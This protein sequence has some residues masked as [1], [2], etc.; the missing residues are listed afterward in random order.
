MPDASRWSLVSDDLQFPESPV[1]SQRDGCLYLVEW[2]GDRVL[3]ICS[4]QQDT[5]FRLSDGSG[6]SGLCQA[7]DGSFWVC[8]FSGRELVHYN[9]KGEPIQILSNYHGAPFRGPCDITADPI[10]GVFFTDSG[11]FEEDW[12]SGRPVGAVY[13][14]A[15]DGVLTRF[16]HDLCYPNG[17]GLSPDGRTLYVSEHRCNRL[18]VYQMDADGRI[19]ER[20]RTKTFDQ[21]CLL[22]QELCFELGPDGLCVMENGEVWVAHYGGGKLIRLNSMGEILGVLRLPSG[23]MPTSVAVTPIV[24]DPSGANLK[25][26]AL[27]I[28]EAEFGYLYR[29]ELELNSNTVFP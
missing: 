15:P 1:W 25:R 24:P 4:D 5:L 14:L 17:I 12:R 27:Y 22:A 28:T 13:Y 21:D 3:K 8:Q 10:G 2:I 6:P 18:L 11:D 7:P 9:I 19:L 26:Y 23:R 20:K 29:C 16:D